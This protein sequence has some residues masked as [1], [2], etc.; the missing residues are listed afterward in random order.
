MFP[1]MTSP[2]DRRAS[3]DLAH[4]GEAIGDP[5]RAAILVALMGGAKPASELARIAGV[6][7]STAT[8]HLNRLSEAG[9]VVVRAQGRHRYYAIASPPVAN[10]VESIAALDL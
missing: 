1:G 6:A 7:P 4:F 5:S 8:S 10:M 3:Y 2:I 9:L